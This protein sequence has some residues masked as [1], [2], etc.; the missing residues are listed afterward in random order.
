MLNEKISSL[1]CRTNSFSASNVR[2]WPELGDHVDLQMAPAIILSQI[3][4]DWD[5]ISNF[6]GNNYFFEEPQILSSCKISAPTGSSYNPTKLNI[7]QG[8][9][10]HLFLNHLVGVDGRTN[11]IAYSNE[12][13]STSYSANL[14]GVD[15]QLS[16]L[17]LSSIGRDGDRYS[18]SPHLPC[19][20]S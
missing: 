20:S 3:N 7:N 10:S 17:G 5:K 16:D 4:P 12:F 19:C 2:F 1:A 18:G 11:E 14:S 6:L 9:G 8:A 15:T 13:P